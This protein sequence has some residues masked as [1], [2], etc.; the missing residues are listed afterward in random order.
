MEIIGLPELTNKQM[1]ELCIDA[2]DAAREYIFSIL[3]MK[4]V[5]RLDISVEVDGTKPLN[6][7]VEVDLL[8]TS[9]IED[10]DCANIVGKSVKEAFKAAKSS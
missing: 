4:A 8:L 6:L 5:D 3:P 2:E 10:V 9:R 1:E 7:K